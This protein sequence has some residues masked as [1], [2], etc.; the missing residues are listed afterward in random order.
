ML[1]GTRMRKSEAPPSNKPAMDTKI[2]G[3]AGVVEFN[4]F[5]RRETDE[6]EHI[7]KQIGPSLSI[8]QRQLPFMQLCKLLDCHP[9]PERGHLCLSLDHFFHF[10]T[11][12]ALFFWYLA[13][14]IFPFYC[15]FIVLLSPA[16]VPLAMRAASERLFYNSDSRIGVGRRAVGPLILLV[17]VPERQLLMTH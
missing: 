2:P 11:S 17:P 15:S 7:L 14:P 4:S 6:A 10:S 3:M 1:L 8:F 5:P 16:R 13:R 9:V 12:D